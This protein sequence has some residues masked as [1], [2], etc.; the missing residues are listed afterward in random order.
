MEDLSG[1]QLGPYRIVSLLGE[2]G[3]AAVYKAYH[4]T[5]DRFVA[6]KILSKHAAG[7]PQ[8]AARFQQEARVLAQ[9]QHPHVLPVYDF[10]EADGYAYLAMP[11]IESGTLVGLMK[12][13]PL[14]LSQVRRIVTQI[15]DALDY[16]HSHGLVHRDVKPSNVLLDSRGNCL[17]TDF[18]IAKIIQSSLRLTPTDGLIGTPAYMSPEQGLGDTLDQRSDIYSLGIILYELATGRPPYEAET[19]MAVVIKHIHDPLPSPRTLNPELPLGLE[20]VILR[21]LAKKREERFATA[22]ELVQALKAAIPET[23]PG[24]PGQIIVPARVSR[25]RG[26]VHPSPWAP[27]GADR[28]RPGNGDHGADRRPEPGVGKPQR[29]AG[30]G[31]QPKPHC[32]SPQARAAPAGPHSLAHCGPVCHARPNAGGYAHARPRIGGGLPGRRH[33]PALRP[34]RGIF[35]RLT[36]DGH[37][38]PGVRDAPALDHVGRLLDRRD[39]GD[40]RNVRGLCSGRGLR[41]AGQRS[42]GHPIQLLR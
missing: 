22:G 16:A 10:G 14:P 11:F 40:K 34:R 30:P 36:R 9:L 13:R 4:A 38:G 33:D 5:M 12:S 6:L 27:G 26:T 2:G 20:Q 32:G 3:M 19:P 31:A 18:G 29:G 25:P 8:F 28:R 42:L 7:D 41:Q 24:H 35:A 37:G 39:R 21:A 23:W 17:L 1:K 15:G